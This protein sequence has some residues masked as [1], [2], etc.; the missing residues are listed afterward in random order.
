MERLPITWRVELG[1]RIMAWETLRAISAHP[2]I[3]KRMVLVL[4]LMRDSD[5]AIDECETV[6][7]S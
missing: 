5:V 6:R 4:V 7:V 1:E 3:P 2:K